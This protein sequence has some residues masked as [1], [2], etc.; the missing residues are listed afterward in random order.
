MRATKKKPALRGPAPL[1]RRFGQG[2][3]QLGQQRWAD[4][5]RPKISRLHDLARAGNIG[6]TDQG[7]GLLGRLGEVIFA[8][9]GAS[10]VEPG[11]EKVGVHLLGQLVLRAGLGETTLAVQ[12]PC[13]RG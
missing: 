6:V 2:R 1:R 4:L 5:Q 8:C 11:A 9:V 7:H 3:T 10:Q 13:P 12:E